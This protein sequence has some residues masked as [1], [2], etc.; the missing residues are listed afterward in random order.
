MNALEIIL[1]IIVIMFVVYLVVLAL[2]EPRYT[3]RSTATLDEILEEMQASLNDLA[4]CIDVG[5]VPV[6]QDAI[7]SLDEFSEAMSRVRL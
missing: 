7:K 2:S 4:A 1:A 5:L 6:F 3:W